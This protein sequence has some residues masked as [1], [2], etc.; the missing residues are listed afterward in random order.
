MNANPALLVL[1]TLAACDSPG[2]PVTASNP[3]AAPAASTKPQA[4]AAKAFR[5]EEKTDLIEF[6][7]SWSA[8]AA[9]VPELV[10]RFQSELAKARTELIGMAE[11]EKQFRD[12]QKLDFNGLMSSNSYQTAGKSARLLSLRV[13]SAAYTGGAHGNSGTGQL[14]WDRARRVEIKP[15]DLFAETANRDRLLTQRWCDALNRARQEKR[16]E[17]VAGGGMFDDCPSL[18]DIAVIPADKDGNGRFEQLQLVASPYVAGSYA[19]GSYEVELPVTA[20]LVAGIRAD[21]RP[22]F[23]AQPPQ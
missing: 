19:E 6:E 9:A 7:F 4:A 23:E 17:P 20:D 15:A 14:I 5:A 16:G 10:A 21:Y 11:A 1:L 12:K 13:D 3:D 2:A 18:D 8:E 22:S